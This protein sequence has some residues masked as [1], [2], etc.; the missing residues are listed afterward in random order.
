M[1]KKQQIIN[2]FILNNIIERIE[3]LEKE[4]NNMVKEIQAD[5]EARLKREKEIEDLT[6]KASEGTG[7]PQS[8]FDGTKAGVTIPPDL[9]KWDEKPSYEQLEEWHSNQSDTIQ[10]LQEEIELFKVER[11]QKSAKIKE[12]MNE[13]GQ[14]D[15]NIQNFESKLNIREAEIREVEKAN[16][17]LQHDLDSMPPAAETFKLEERVAELEPFEEKYT[18]LRKEM[19]ELQESIEFPAGK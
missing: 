1:N 2:R 7:L 8:V 9:K 11:D 13:S 15:L 5:K 18:K 6:N 16:K 17:N 3:R 4:V 12:L 19:E 10:N 14:L